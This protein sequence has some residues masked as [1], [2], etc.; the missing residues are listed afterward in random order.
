MIAAYRRSHPLPPIDFRAINREALAS[1]PAV[2]SRLLP[3]GHRE[4]NEYLA[5][6]PH[7]VDHHLGSF[8]VNL[9]TG[10]WADF[11]TRDKGGDIISLVAFVEDCSQVAAAKKLARMLGLDAGGRRNG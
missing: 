6:N 9:N 8:K 1:L 5:V 4:G 10:R 3:R 2:L 11:A 7:R